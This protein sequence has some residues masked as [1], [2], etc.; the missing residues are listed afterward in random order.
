MKRVV[1]D[2]SALISLGVSGLFQR[3]LEIAEIVIP[4]TVVEELKEIGAF[5]DSEGKAAKMILK[6]W[7]QKKIKKTKVDSPKKILPLLSS[8][9]DEGEAECFVLCLE[10]KI[11]TLIMDDVNAGYALESLAMANGIKLKI[12]VALVSELVRQGKI[13]KKEAL[14]AVRKMAKIREWEGGVM[15]HLAKRYFGV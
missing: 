3:C 10:N 8:D 12:S 2:T 9:V 1:M 6:K 11:D 4:E 13:N 5:K 14:E 7:K 15:E